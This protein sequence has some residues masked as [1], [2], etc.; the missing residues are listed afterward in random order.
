VVSDRQKA[1]DAEHARK[2][3]ENED[4]VIK[5]AS[6]PGATDYVKEVAEDIK[7]RRA[8]YDPEGRNN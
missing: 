3:K 1:R 6:Q 5:M 2:V 8:G 7:M 4:G